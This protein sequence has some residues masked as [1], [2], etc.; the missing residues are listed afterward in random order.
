MSI[1]LFFPPIRYVARLTPTSGAATLRTL[2]IRAGVPCRATGAWTERLVEVVV[3]HELG[4]TAE[5]G[6]GAAVQIAMPRSEPRQMARLALAAM[7]YALHDLVA[8]ESIRGQP[9]ATIAT[10]RGRIRTGTALSTRERQRRFRESRP[11]RRGR[12]HL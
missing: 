11:H 8:K 4:I 1:P 2:C 3:A 7:A 9:W 10:P 6:E 5:P 12:L